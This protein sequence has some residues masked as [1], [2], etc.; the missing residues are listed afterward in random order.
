MDVRII[1]TGFV[2]MIIVALGGCSDPAS[3]SDVSPS[4]GVPS[5]SGVSNVTLGGTATKGIISFGNVVAEELKADGTV[6]AQVGNA[7][8]GV[9]GRYSLTVNSAYLGGP[10][11][12]TVSADENTQMKCDIV[13][14]CGARV[15]GLED[16]L[17][18][19]VV[20][21]GEWYKPGSLNMM[22]LVAE[23]ATNHTIK[24]NITPYTHLAAN[25]ALAVNNTGIASRALDIGSLTSTGIYLANSEVSDL[26]DLDILKTRPVDITDISAIISGDP[27]EVVYAAVS[28]AVLTGDETAGGA[29]DVNGALGVLS[30]SFDGGTIAA[31]DMQGIIDGAL[32]VLDQWWCWQ[33]R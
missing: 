32:R 19:T 23:A 18:P 22:A 15:D 21:F 20:D 8:T 27:T 13:E 17:N 28:A 1:F 25:Y 14:G 24:V 5:S 7:T 33:H 10:I 3:D 30:R 9:D 6:L 11:K 16:I 4:S 26:L 2:G 29:P 31:S 12:V